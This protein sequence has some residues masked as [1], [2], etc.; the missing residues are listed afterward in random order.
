MPFSIAKVAVVF[1]STVMRNNFSSAGKGRSGTMAC[2]YLL[3]LEESTN[4]H[5]QDRYAAKLWAENSTQRSIDVLPDPDED[6]VETKKKPSLPPVFESPSDTA[7]ILDPG[8]TG[9][10]PVSF[11]DS[12]SRGNFEVSFT[13]ALKGVLDLHTARRMKPPGEGKRAKQG[14]SIP[15]Q[16]RWLNY[17]ALILA[18]AAPSHLWAEPPSSVPPALTGTLS[19]TPSLSPRSKLASK[20]KVRLT[21][22]RLRMHEPS[23]M[24]NLVK[25]ANVLLERAARNPPVIDSNTHSANQVWASLARYDDEL[26]KHLERWE[27]YTRDKSGTMGK[28]RVVLKTGKTDEG[29]N[30]IVSFE[31]E[32]GEME[33]LFDAA[34]R[35]DRGKMVR[36]FA[37]LGAAE[38]EVTEE[39]DK[40]TQFIMLL[41]LMRTNP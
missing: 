28:R 6:Q 25:A 36:S 16:R 24:H 34:G 22:I 17:W 18:H 26:V 12:S 20:P 27:A 3:S 41:M 32:E 4:I 8:E 15:S 21:Q 19:P 29:R 11:T 30:E 33:R 10:P 35:W 31:E 14:V 2:T 38:N 39:K 23:A 1:L 5:A 7:G 9:S 37:R 40:V 13:D